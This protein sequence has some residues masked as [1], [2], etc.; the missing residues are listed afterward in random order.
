MI[1]LYKLAYNEFAHYISRMQQTFV[2]PAKGL[3]FLVHDVGRHLRRKIDQRAQA[4]GLTSA[5]WR[6]L[7]AVAR[8]ELQNQEPLNQAGL[9]EQ[10]E[11]EPITLSRLIDRMESAGLIERRADPA[12]RRAYR[13]YLTEAAR[14]VVADF[15]AIAY[16]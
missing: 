9:A 8:T 16:D 2:P 15:R 13:L 6:V 14:P 3:G 12:D 10:L 7:A 11:V 4:I 5:Q 1:H